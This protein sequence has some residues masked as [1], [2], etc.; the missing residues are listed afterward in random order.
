M[1][2][3]VAMTWCVGVRVVMS[4]SVGTMTVAEAVR[5]FL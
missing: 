4:V 3:G 1:S 2:V 5:A